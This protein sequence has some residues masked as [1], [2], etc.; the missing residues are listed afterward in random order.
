APVTR[1]QFATFLLA[2]AKYSGSDTSGRAD[3][4]G[5]NDYAKISKW[6]RNAVSWAVDGGMISGTG[7][8]NL[9]P[10]ATANRA[11]VAQMVMKFAEKYGIG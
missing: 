7:G 9:S 10:E 5:Y 4:T 2:Y 3:I 11:Q 8:N 1:E 6:A